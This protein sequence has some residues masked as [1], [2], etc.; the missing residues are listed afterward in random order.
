M[1]GTKFVLVVVWLALTF[2]VGQ[3]GAEEPQP[4]E[5]EQQPRK[6]KPELTHLR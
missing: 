1:T 5:A 4:K 3:A 6:G 2:G